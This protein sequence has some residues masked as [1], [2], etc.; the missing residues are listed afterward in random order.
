MQ[1]QYLSS[2]YLPY[3][4]TGR[5]P[6]STRSKNPWWR[7][8][9]GNRSEIYLFGLVLSNC[10]NFRKLPTIS[11]TWDESEA[12]GGDKSITNLYPSLYPSYWWTI[13]SSLILRSSVNELYWSSYKL[14]RELFQK[15]CPINLLDLLE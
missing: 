15:Y 2:F 14:P 11:K 8:E 12:K 6:Y 9:V 13:E 7:Y 5:I 4:K 1:F 10:L 3:Q